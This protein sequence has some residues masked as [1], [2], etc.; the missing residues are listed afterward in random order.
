MSHSH[1]ILGKDQRAVIRIPD[2]QG[3]IAY[4]PSQTSAPPVLINGSDDRKIRLVRL[5]KCTQSVYQFGRVIES[6]VPSQDGTRTADAWLC[7]EARFSRRMKGAVDYCNAILRMG[8]SAIWTICGDEVL[9]LFDLVAGHRLAVE[10][11]YSELNAHDSYLAS[12]NQLLNNSRVLRT[13][14]VCKVC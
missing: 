11:P 2:R 13:C 8:A 9:D 7:F 10:I 3:P 5:R 14:R 6:T 4:E 12:S 1:R